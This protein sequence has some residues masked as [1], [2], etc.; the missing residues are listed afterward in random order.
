MKGRHQDNLEFAQW[1][2][3]FFNENNDDR[4]EVCVKISRVDEG[5]LERGKTKTSFRRAKTVLKGKYSLKKSKSVKIE[6]ESNILDRSKLPIKIKDETAK[7][8]SVQPSQEKSIHE[9]SGYEKSVYEKS[10]Y[11]NHSEVSDDSGALDIQIKVDASERINDFERKLSMCEFEITELKN[12]F[13]TLEKRNET[14]LLENN[15]LKF[16]LGGLE[17]VV[18]QVCQPFSVGI[19]SKWDSCHNE[20]ENQGNESSESNFASHPVSPESALDPI[21]IDVKS[22]F[23]WDSYYLFFLHGE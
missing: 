18:N 6:R 13:S 8:R 9:K 7:N 3:E 10:V 14:L 1:F 2:V 12:M 16:Q 5:R 4:Y 15:A 11:D 21:E 23:D 17:K 19:C 22:D 20:L